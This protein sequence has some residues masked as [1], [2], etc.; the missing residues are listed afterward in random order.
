MWP[1]RWNMKSVFHSVAMVNPTESLHCLSASVLSK[2]QTTGWSH[3]TSS[4]DSALNLKENSNLCKPH[5]F[6]RG[7]Q[8]NEMFP[9]RHRLLTVS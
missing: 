6:K 5:V 9:H 7:Y 2:S 8:Q 1:P 3:K 4:F